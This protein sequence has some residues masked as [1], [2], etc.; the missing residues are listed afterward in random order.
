[1]DSGWYVKMCNPQLEPDR[2]RSND[3]L[4][5]IIITRFFLSLSVRAFP[6]LSF[7]RCCRLATSPQLIIIGKLTRNSTTPIDTHTTD[8][9]AHH[10]ELDGFLNLIN[11]W[12]N[13]VSVSQKKNLFFFL[14]KFSTDFGISSCPPIINT[15]YISS[16]NKPHTKHGLFAVS[17]SS[18]HCSFA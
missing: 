9:A 8:T 5:T 4:S 1:M 11:I 10:Q 2:T 3:L 6:F 14:Q 13:Y 15:R 7:T 12:L 17:S 18:F 16:T